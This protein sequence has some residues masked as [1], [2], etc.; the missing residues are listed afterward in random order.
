M[1]G[2]CAIDHVD[3]TDQAFLWLE[4]AGGTVG[5]AKGATI[6]YLRCPEN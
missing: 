5:D 2:G 1:C 6:K 3:F 4:P